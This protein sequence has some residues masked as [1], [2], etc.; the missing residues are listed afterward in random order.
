MSQ[1]TYQDHETYYPESKSN[2]CLFNWIFH[3]NPMNKLWNAI[4]RDLYNQYWDNLNNKQ[5]IKSTQISTL[6]DIVIKLSNS[7]LDLDKL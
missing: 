6:V 1:E 4:P 3:Y 5:V 2:D 7:D